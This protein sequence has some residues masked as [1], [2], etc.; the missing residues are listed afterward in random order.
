ML[1]STSE[2]RKWRGRPFSVWILICLLTSKVI[3]ALS[4]KN[5]VQTAILSSFANFSECTSLKLESPNTR[6]AV[7]ASCA[8]FQGHIVEISKPFHIFCSAW[9]ILEIPSVD[10]FLGCLHSRPFWKRQLLSIYLPCVEDLRR[11]HRWFHADRLF[12]LYLRV[13]L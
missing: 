2:E 13:L 3:D 8:M 10:R 4:C 7:K 11:F 12:R 5:K 6:F 9:K 1:S